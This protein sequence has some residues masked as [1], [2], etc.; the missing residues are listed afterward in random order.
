MTTRPHTVLF[1]GAGA[2][3]SLGFRTTEKQASF[4]RKLAPLPC[5]SKP[6]GTRVRTALGDGV[7]DRWVSGFRDL[8]EVLGDRLDARDDKLSV[9]E[10]SDEQTET[11]RR[12]AESVDRHE[13]LQHIVGLRSLYDW[14]ALVSA[15]NVCPSSAPPAADGAGSSSFG[16]GFGLLDL[17]NLLDMHE[18]S[19]HGFPDRHGTFLPPQRVIGARAALGLLIQSLFYIDWH[20]RARWNPGLEHHYA[21]ALE[22]ARRMQRQGVVFS[23]RARPDDYEQLE[24]IL[25]DVSF[26]SMNWDPFGPWAQFVANRSLNGAPDVPHV[27]APACRMQ[28]YH[29][30][31]YY[32]AGPRVDKAHAGS[33]VWQPMNVAS[34]RQLN[35]R[36]HGSDVRIR[37]SRYLFPHGC[38]WWRECPNCGKLSSFIGDE[39]QIASQT[40]LPPP[41]LAA[42]VNVGQFESWTNTVLEPDRRHEID[43][44]ERGNVD[45][46]ACVHCRTLTHAHHT[47]VVMQTSFKG[48]LPPFLEEIQ[49]ELRVVIQEAD[50]IVLM[51]YSLPLDD[52]TYRAFLASRIR[53]DAKRPVRCSV[54]GQ[55]PSYERRWVY[56]D[57]LD[58][59]H[60]L[61]D[62]VSRA[63]QLFGASNVRYFG[64]G[65][66]DVFLAGDAKVTEQAVER[67][68]TWD[69]P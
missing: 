38:L 60:D 46:R 37:V 44:W 66:P 23:E 11:M 68:L 16:T 6:L 15:I 63:Q 18:R 22:L 13:L 43:E 28:L 1:W 24:F 14:P 29:D 54:V 34:A 25:G 12:N 61:P 53:K 30:L 5:D 47:P 69:P 67:L 33:R 27:E 49:R 39:W 9:T 20:A 26:V 57:E 48:E 62:V 31:G 56:P 4:L 58:P 40:L 51:G 41:P 7:S 10:I 45:A 64:G 35:D 3:A 59:F 50:H 17:F 21:F 19:G 42:F 36:K 8:L 32:I 52:V 65:I 2:T 55:H